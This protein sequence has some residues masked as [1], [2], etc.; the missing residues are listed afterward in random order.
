MIFSREERLTLGDPFIWTIV[1][2]GL[3]LYERSDPRVA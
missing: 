3:V 2:E 1:N